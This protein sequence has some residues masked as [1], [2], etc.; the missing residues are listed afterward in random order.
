MDMAILIMRL[1]RLHSAACQHN[2]YS[3]DADSVTSGLASKID[4][5]DSGRIMMHWQTHSVL[6]VIIANLITI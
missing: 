5:G 3:V 4:N 6:P 1:H 2:P